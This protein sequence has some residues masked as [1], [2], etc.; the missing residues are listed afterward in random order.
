MHRQV[1]VKV[2]AE[3]DEGVADLVGILSAV[4]G[5][6]TVESCQGTPKGREPAFVTFCYGRH[7]RELSW[8]VFAVIG[9][10]LSQAFD[11][12][13]RVSIEFVGEDNSTGTIE[14]DPTAKQK[15]SRAIRRAIRSLCPQR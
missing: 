6:R 15:V 11:C 9:P 5:L 13:V 4:P 14:F 1:W 8:F 3:V 2:N 12:N 10:A 7:W